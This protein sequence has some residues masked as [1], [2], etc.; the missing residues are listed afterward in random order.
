MY[1]PLCRPCLRVVT[2]VSDPVNTQPAPSEHATVAEEEEREV[3]S[4]LKKSVSLD[5]SRSVLITGD[6][7]GTFSTALSRKILE[8]LTERVRASDSTVSDQSLWTWFAESVLADRSIHQNPDLE[9]TANEFIEAVYEEMK[10]RMLKPG[11]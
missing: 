3:G 1:D 2:V 11:A 6:S 8:T 10:K 5:E 4:N 7:I 9:D